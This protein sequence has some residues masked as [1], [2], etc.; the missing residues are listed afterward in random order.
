MEEDR[1][2]RRISFLLYMLSSGFFFGSLFVYIQVLA[3]GWLLPC[4]SLLSLIVCNVCALVYR[5]LDH[6]EIKIPPARTVFFLLATCNLVFI[7]F[8]LA[9]LP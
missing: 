9:F 2:R 4:I 8:L 7:T 3:E 5:R 6:N 1:I